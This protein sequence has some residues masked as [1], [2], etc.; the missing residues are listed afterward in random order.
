MFEDRFSCSKSWQV[1]YGGTETISEYI[2]AKDL[3]S[4]LDEIIQ[5]VPWKFEKILWT[6]CSPLQNY[7]NNHGYNKI[8][9]FSLYE[10]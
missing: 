3:T 10:N 6:S 4:N 9:H 7:F 2:I 1:S 5:R 8:N